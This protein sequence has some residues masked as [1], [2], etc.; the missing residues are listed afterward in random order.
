M[1][2]AEPDAAAPSFLELLM[3]VPKLLWTSSA[4]RKICLCYLSV[5]FSQ[6]YTTGTFTADAVAQ[7]IGPA[8]V[9]AVMATNNTMEVRCHF[10]CAPR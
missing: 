10:S 6:S 2:A 7:E 4:A 8:F 9:G 5:G 3:A 1:E